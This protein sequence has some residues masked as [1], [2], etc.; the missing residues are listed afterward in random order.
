MVERN[1]NVKKLHS[2]AVP[3]INIDPYFSM[4]SFA[5][6]L[7][8]DTVRHWTGACNSMSG[9][10]R[11]DGKAYRF[12]GKV[13]PF[14]R[15]YYCEPDILPQTEVNI[16]PT[17]TEYKFE[18][19]DL[20]LTVTF[21]SPLIINDLMLMS[22]PVSYIKYDIDVKNGKQI[23]TEIYFDISSEC[24][25]DVPSQ[26]VNIFKS[27]FGM[28]MGCTTQNVLGKCGDDVRIDYG[29][30]H[31]PEKDAFSGKALVTRDTFARNRQYETCWDYKPLKEN[32]DYNIFEDDP[33]LVVVRREKQGIITIAYDDIKS[34]EY[35]GK[36][37]DCYYKL[38]GDTFS[39]MLKKAIDEKETVINKC[40]AFD[41]EA[42]N[43][44]K[45]IS[46]TYAGIFAI[47]YRQA[48]A[49]HKLAYDE[50]GIIFVSKECGS[51][52][53]AATADI[54]YPSMPLFYLYNIELIKG[55]L[56]PIFDFAKTDM[57]NYNFAPHDVGLYPKLNGQYYGY[58]EKLRICTEDMQMPIE[59]CGNMLICSYAVCNKEGNNSYAE[60]HK[61][62]LTKWAEYLIDY[63][64][65]PG[66]QL[67][68]DDFG[69]H[70]NHNCNLSIKCIIGLYCYG[71]MFD[72]ENYKAKAREFAMEWE[73]QAKDCDHYKMSFDSTDT[74]SI[75]YNII[76]DKIWNFGLFSDEVFK[77]E[78]DYY[79]TKIKKYGIPLDYRGDVGKLDWIMWA[80]AMSDDKEYRDK[81][82]E[83]VS[84]MICGTKQ[85]VPLADY[86]NVETGEQVLWA[87]YNAPAGF[88]NR[89][90]V[91]G[92]AILMI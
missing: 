86:Y 63:G 74:W 69:G 50:N 92:L 51:N 39:D 85:R 73:K 54:T 58:D 57:W 38:N 23:D 52:G 75:K 4:W 87:F 62:L 55:M 26:K 42:I 37:L 27:D 25:V 36:Q 84:A 49:A 29:Y 20:I 72:N 6:K 28:Y 12:M 40:I 9:M 68:T 59:E 79:L 33:V 48:V 71:M 22:R 89:S 56:R 35:F 19:D 66:E 7:Y 1:D 64:F 46:S 13:V 18:N 65:D 8:D 45:T 91:G 34:I 31:L 61:E 76:W 77:K 53:C 21:V 15:Y 2:P 41:N 78:T 10:I 67:C 11:Y 17:R 47:T 30:L 90:V 70:L 88:T 81:V 14:E 16:Y 32:T 83:S 3:I 43:K 82:I 60:E 24:C 80:A 44:A 5:D